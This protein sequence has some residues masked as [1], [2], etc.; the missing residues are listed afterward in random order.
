MPRLST[1]LQK[2]GSNGFTPFRSFCPA[3]FPVCLWRPLTLCLI[4]T[5]SGEEINLVAADLILSH[6]KNVKVI[7]FSKASEKVSF[8]TP[9]FL[10]P[11]F[12]I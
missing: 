6:L 1:H 11:S 12:S 3:L 2:N 10:Q 4:G 7:C 8:Q 9:P 5:S